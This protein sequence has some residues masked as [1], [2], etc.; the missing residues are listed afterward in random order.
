[1][2]L[3]SVPFLQIQEKGSVTTMKLSRYTVA[4]AQQASF[5]QLPKFLFAEPYLSGLSNDGKILYALLRDRHSLSL[6]NGWVNNNNEIF[7][8][9]SRQD[10][11]EMIGRSLP[12]VRKVMKELIEYGLIEEEICEGYAPR[13]YLT[14]ADEIS[15]PSHKPDPTYLTPSVQNSE[16]LAADAAGKRNAEKAVKRAASTPPKESFPLPEKT[17]LPPRKNL[18]P[19]PKESFPELDL[20]NN[21]NN[22]KNNLSINHNFSKDD[23]NQIDGLNYYEQ[24]IKEIDAELESI[25][26]ADGE[27]TDEQRDRLNQLHSR[28][29]LLER[30]QIDYSQMSLLAVEDTVREQIDYDSLV[31]RHGSCEH[32]SDLVNNIVA[33]VAEQLHEKSISG[34][35][36]ERYLQLQ[37]SHIEHIVE[38]VNKYGKEIKNP[39]RF[40]E[41]V[42]YNALCSD[43]TAMANLF[44]TTYLNRL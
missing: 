19:S 23:S 35:T 21:N 3:L 16:D 7:I 39:K 11:C 31:G 29:V 10:M 4:A 20:E 41:R 13:I 32:D 1:M 17:F 25:I 30:L 27:R 24:K 43:G 6:K 44:A 28:R 14:T 33:L 26:T 8:L 5:Y 36:K 18:S 9:Y 34:D 12:T 40:L 15:F 37:S 2:A 42:I 22:N 38:S